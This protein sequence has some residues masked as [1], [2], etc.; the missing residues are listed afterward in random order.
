MTT[1]VSPLLPYVVLN[2]FVE[3]PDVASL[4]LTERTY[5]W[6]NLIWIE[7]N[8]LKKIYRNELLQHQQVDSQP[9]RT[10]S[11]FVRTNFRIL[12]D[13]TIECVRKACR[14]IKEK[15]LGLTRPVFHY[16]GHLINKYEA[17]VFWLND[18]RYTGKLESLTL[19]DV[20]TCIGNPAI[21]I[22]DCFSA[23]ELMAGAD[24]YP[25][26]VFLASCSRNE[27]LPVW[28]DLFSRVLSCPV[29]TALEVYVL[30]SGNPKSIDLNQDYQWGRHSIMGQLDWA[31][32][33]ITDTIAS[34]SLPDDMFRK[35]FREDFLLSTIMR[36]FL[37]AQRLMKAHGKTTVSRPALPVCSN[38]K[39]WQI[40]DQLVEGAVRQLQKTNQEEYSPMDIFFKWILAED[41]GPEMLPL[42][43]HA[44]LI[45]KHIPLALQRLQQMEKCILKDASLFQMVLNEIAKFSNSPTKIDAESA[46]DFLYEVFNKDPK[47]LALP[48]IFKDIK[49][50]CLLGKDPD[51]IMIRRAAHLQLGIVQHFKVP[52]LRSAK[53]K[54]FQWLDHPDPDVRM[55]CILL[56]TDTQERKNFDRDL[57][58]KLEA[59][60][61]NDPLP[62]VRIT[63]VVGL[64]SFVETRPAEK[65]PLVSC[66]L[67]LIPTCANSMLRQAF[68]EVLH[69]IALSNIANL[70]DAIRQATMP[71][72]VQTN[73]TNKGRPNSK[74]NKNKPVSKT[75]RQNQTVM[76]QLWRAIESLKQDP[77][78]KVS[79]PLKTL[80]SFLQKKSDHADTVS[81]KALKKANSAKDE[82][83]PE[84]INKAAL[85]EQ[86]REGLKTNVDQNESFQFVNSSKCHVGYENGC[87]KDIHL[88]LV[89]P[90]QKQEN[91]NGVQPGSLNHQLGSFQI[92]RTPELLCFGSE[93]ELAVASGD[94]I[95]WLN[96]TKGNDFRL[97]SPGTNN[98]VT[99]LRFL[100][101]KQAAEKSLLAGHSDGVVRI[102]QPT[103]HGSP[104]ELVNSWQALYNPCDLS[105]SDSKMTTGK[106]SVLLMDLTDDSVLWVGG[107]DCQSI[108]S[109]DLQVEKSTMEL[110][111]GSEYPMTALVCEGSAGVLFGLVDG[112]LRLLDQRGTR[113]SIGLPKHGKSIQKICV[114]SDGITI[115]SVCTGADINVTDLR[116]PLKPLKQ[117]SLEGKAPLVDAAICDRK[118]LIVSTNG[119]EVLVNSLDDGQP[120]YTVDRSDE[121]NKSGSKKKSPLC[122]A[123]HPS[124]CLQAVGYKD[125]S[126]YLFSNSTF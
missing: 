11:H 95:T 116:N 31:L 61:Q 63:A 40:W 8:V 64:I 46:I 83:T 70:V 84:I 30:K 123:L 78:P 19:D 60:L 47:V 112:S 81:R 121:I 15:D 56:L 2:S 33:L 76:L 126:V 122:V 53:F 18:D 43:C 109:W 25:E 1:R 36:R 90:D 54:C 32:T 10:E 108:R 98:Q 115:V 65:D 50:F 89:T 28:K 85:L 88:E 13:S 71:D 21:H 114:C 12:P 106:K 44:L 107:L 103:S 105:T 37:L 38:H 82:W 3:L 102:W 120:L 118:R 101:P 59:L 6:I 17:G 55:W 99:A 91:G 119:K 51:P 9:Y 93:D 79:G 113:T 29:T 24:N 86:L 87:S 77:E 74:Q 26:C 125:N 66:I 4:R 92:K 42:I 94:R 58:I 35:L 39:L 68:V 57:Q 73:K 67:R 16:C 124:K 34:Q 23:E 100:R 97:K 111:T 48:Q 27:Q 5:S 22:Y 75:L 52:L 72:Y 62:K 41:Q 49:V 117:W 7:D 69:L 14:L 110:D 45:P 20:Q 104:P 80:V 96:Q